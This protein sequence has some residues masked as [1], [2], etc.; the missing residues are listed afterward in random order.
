MKPLARPFVITTSMRAILE[1]IARYRM[2]SAEQILT[3]T[4]RKSPTSLNPVLNKLLAEG[5]LT[6]AR[7]HVDEPYMYLL[8]PLAAEYLQTFGDITVETPIKRAKVQ[9]LKAEP[10]QHTR[11]MNDAL[12]A[13][14]QLAA[15]SLPKSP[16]LG[17]C[18]RCAG[19]LSRQSATPSM[20]EATP[21]TRCVA[22]MACISPKW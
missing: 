8:T 10:L 21:I 19:R 16:L 18:A 1:A 12:I 17:T 15:Q 20:A 3:L 14:E 7:E 4:N 2:L 11:Y 9:H 22:A 5:Y 13:F 6:R